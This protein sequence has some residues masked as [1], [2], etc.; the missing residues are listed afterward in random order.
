MVGQGFQ[1]FAGD[2]IDL[3]LPFFHAGHVILEADPAALGLGGLEAQQVRDPVPVGK[4]GMHPFFEYR[5]EL[6]IK[7]FVLLLVHTVQKPQDL[8]NQVLADISDHGVLLQD[9]PADVEV[10]V[11]SVHHALDK[12][13]VFGE[14]LPAIVHD[15]NPF[16]VKR[17]AVFAARMKQ[18]EG[19][20]GGDVK[21]GHI[22]GHPFQFHVE[23]GQG[24]IPVVAEMLVK[25]LVLLPGDFVLVFEPDGFHGVQGLFP[26]H[27]F[28]LALDLFSL[29]VHQSVLV[30][31]RFL[32]FHVHDNR[33]GH[34]IGMLFDD[35][36]Q[37]IFFGK[38]LGLFI[39]L[40]GRLQLQDDAGATLRFFQGFNGV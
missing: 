18:F 8:F 6:S 2:I 3:L 17:Q 27:R 28:C 40:G 14:Q 35:M 24:R 39:T 4:I 1:I 26:D 23:V 21:Q 13:K 32:A 12:A 31:K 11:R 36:P 10:Q 25:L 20:L 33:V 30:G 15:K 34:E 7:F 37:G 5:S 29:P 22:L 16:T 9:L 38:I 19:R